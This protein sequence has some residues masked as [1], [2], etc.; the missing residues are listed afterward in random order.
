MLCGDLVGCA[1]R[2][3]EILPH[4]VNWA[5]Q[6]VQDIP[7]PPKSL[8]IVRQRVGVYSLGHCN[9]LSSPQSVPHLMMI[10]NNILVILRKETL[11]F[12]T[13][14]SATSDSIVFSN[15]IHTPIVWEA[16]VCPSPTSSNDLLLLTISPLGVEMCVVEDHHLLTGSDPAPDCF[17]PLYQASIY[18]DSP[19]KSPWYHLCAGGTGQRALWISVN[20]ERANGPPHFIY[21]SVPPPSSDIA[22]V[23]ISWSNDSLDQPALWA[24]PAIDFDEALGFTVVGNVFRELAVYDHDGQDASSCAGLATD[25]TDQASPLLPLQS[26]VSGASYYSLSS[27]LDKYIDAHKSRFTCC[28]LLEHAITLF[29]KQAISLCEFGKICF[30]MVQG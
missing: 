15:L 9:K 17:S 8:N 2:Q 20:P 11:E 19:R 12:Y 28:A 16:A 6:R 29:E 21:S 4:I 25:F 22:K 26:T 27:Q 1:L 24:I 30:H 13:L 7:S 18:Y 5:V 10:W 23:H 3:G 14:S